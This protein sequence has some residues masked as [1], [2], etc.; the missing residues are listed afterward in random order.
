M[1]NSICFLCVV[2]LIASFAGCGK[3]GSYNSQ[4]PQ[5]G[6]MQS[7]LEQKVTKE[8]AQQAFAEENIPDILAISAGNK[9]G[10][11]DF[12][13]NG[14]NPEQLARVKEFMLKKYQENQKE[15]GY[16][17]SQLKEYYWHGIDGVKGY[18][19]MVNDITGKEIQKFVKKLVKQGNCI[20]VS[21]NGK[22]N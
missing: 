9:E 18:E 8:M 16:W 11:D 6:E 15:N 20:E 13:K 17:I 1:K 2:L 12:I 21:I 4:N 22:N 5:Q 10:L 7:D 19:Q 3:S 14:P